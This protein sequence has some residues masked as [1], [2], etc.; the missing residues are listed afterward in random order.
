MDAQAPTTKPEA[1]T[2]VHGRIYK[3]SEVEWGNLLMFKKNEQVFFECCSRKANTISARIES[4][5]HQ[6][7]TESIWESASFVLKSSFLT[8]FLYV[9]ESFCFPRGRKNLINYEY[10][11]TKIREKG[12]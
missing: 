4:A 9:S 12:P 3:C 5:V 2:A 7:D 1:S 11:V 8:I 10:L 6:G